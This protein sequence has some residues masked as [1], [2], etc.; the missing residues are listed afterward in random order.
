MSTG[1]VRKTQRPGKAPSKL[2]K[3]GL[4]IIKP[5]EVL[6]NEGDKAKSLYII[7]RGQLRLFRPKGKGYIELAVLRAGEVIGEMSYFDN[8][9]GGK[10]S[11]SAAALV[12]T[13]VIEISFT[14]FAKTMA[15]LNPWFKT[16]INTLADRL[17]NTNSKVKEL[18]SNS[19]SVDYSTGKQKGYEFFKNHDVIKVLGTLFLVLKSHGEKNP[20]GVAVHKKTLNLYSNEIFNINE[21]KT[22]TIFHIFQELGLLELQ[23]DQDGFPKILVFKELESIRGLFIFFNTQKHL[24]ED[25]KLKIGFKCEAFLEKVWERLKTQEPPEIGMS[26]LEID[27]LLAYWKERK[28]DIGLDHLEEARTHAIVGEVIVGDQNKLLLEVS[29]MKLQKLLPTIR[30]M[31]M[32]EKCNREKSAF[33]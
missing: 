10:R 27:D 31:N 1:S 29:Y 13:E 18:E 16:I 3:S 15:G 28:M 19:T 5:G 2:A 23:K 8:D 33:A 7:Q 14:A 21:A 11:C 4:K 9:N 12:S 32:V 26:I 17:R 30:F 25:K 20:A 24:T 22:E 6:F